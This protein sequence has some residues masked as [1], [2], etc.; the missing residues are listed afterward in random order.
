MSK[1][2]DNLVDLFKKVFVEVI[3]MFVY[4]LEFLVIYIVDLFGVLGD[5]MCLL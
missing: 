1:L 3:K 4:D 2:F 5:V